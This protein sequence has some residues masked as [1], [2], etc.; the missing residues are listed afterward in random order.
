MKQFL[1]RYRLTD[2]TA[3]EWHQ[4]IARFIAALDGD[5]EL[6]GKISYRCMKIRDDSAYY[7]LATAADDQAIK[8]LQQR[9]F[10]KRYTETT[11]RVAG[12]DV[13]VSPLEIIAETAP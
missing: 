11:K 6:K 1:I 4:E 8:T 5:G 2:A 10:F 12:G 3:A 13:V 7:H 9:E